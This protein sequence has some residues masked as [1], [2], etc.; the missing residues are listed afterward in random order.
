MQLRKPT[1]HKKNSNLADVN[2][3][4]FFQCILVAL[5]LLATPLMASPASN[6]V[7]EI[8]LEIEE[9]CID[10]AL[11]EE[12]A[13][14][15][16]ERIECWTPSAIDSILTYNGLKQEGIE[17]CGLKRTSEGLQSISCDELQSSNANASTCQ[18]VVTIVDTVTT[19]DLSIG[20]TCSYVDTGLIQQIQN[21]IKDGGP[22][23]LN[24]KSDALNLNSLTVCGVVIPTRLI[25]EYLDRISPCIAESDERSEL[26]YVKIEDPEVC[27]FQVPLNAL[28]QLVADQNP[29]KDIAQDSEAQSVQLVQDPT[30]CGVTIP[31]EAVVDYINRN[32]PCKD[33]EIPQ[34]NF[35]ILLEDPEACGHTIPYQELRDKIL[36]TNPCKDELDSSTDAMEVFDPMG[37]ED[38]EVCQQTIPLGMVSRELKEQYDW[39]DDSSR[40]IW[41]AT[42][43][44]V[45]CD[46]PTVEAPET[47]K[48][49]ESICGLPAPGPLAQEIIAYARNCVDPNNEL[50]THS[51]QPP[52]DSGLFEKEYCDKIWN[53]AT[54]PLYAA[55]GIQDED[56]DGV[57]TIKLCEQDVTVRPGE[58]KPVQRGDPEPFIVLGD[59][60]DD[61]TTNPAPALDIKRQVDP[62]C[63]GHYVLGATVVY[64]GQTITRPVAGNLPC[65]LPYT[66]PEYLAK[67]TQGPDKDR[68]KIPGFVTLHYAKLTVYED[69]T[70]GEEQTRTIEYQ[71]DFDDEDPIVHPRQVWYEVDRNLNKIGDE[72][73]RFWE[74]VVGRALD[75]SQDFDNDGLD[76]VNEFQWDLVPICVENQYENCQD[77]EKDRYSGYGGD[78]WMDG[79]EVF[80]FNDP[81]NDIVGD[82]GIGA[83]RDPDAQND[84]DEDGLP[85][86]GDVDADNDGLLDGDEY[87]SYGL[88]PEF[89]D[90]DCDID[91]VECSAAWDSI[92]RFDARTGNPG[93]GDGINDGEEVYRW[94]ETSGANWN[95]DSD[96][97]GIKNILDPDSDNDELLDGQEFA[98]NGQVL[99]HVEDTDGDGLLDGQEIQWNVDSDGDGLLNAADWD[100]DN[101]G[102]S[103]SWEVHYGFD[104]TNPADANEDPDA[105]LL[106]NLQEFLYNAIENGTPQY[107]GGTDPLDPDTDD[108]ELLDGEEVLYAGTS[109]FYWDTDF[110]TLPDAWEFTYRHAKLNPLVA[111]GGKDADGDSYDYAWCKNIGGAYSNYREYRWQIPA[112]WDSRP[113]SEGGNGV[114]WHGTNPIELDTDGDGAPDGYEIC[115][116]LNPLA[117]DFI[118]GDDPD[119][120]GLDN[121]I[122]VTI[123]TSIQLVDS[124]NDGLCDGG[125]TPNC[126]PYP[127]EYHGWTTTIQGN[128]R[129]VQSNPTDADSDDDFLTDLQEFLLGTLPEDEDTDNDSVIDG[130]E[131]DDRNA[132][133][134]E[135]NTDPFSPDTDDDGLSDHAERVLG[136]DPT[137]QDSDDDGI[138]DGAEVST[139]GT[140]PTNHDTDYDY[141]PDPLELGL[142]TLDGTIPWNLSP[143]VADSDGDGLLDGEEV[144]FYDLDP[145]NSDSDCDLTVDGHDVDP[146][147]SNLGPGQTLTS[148]QRE[149]CGIYAAPESALVPERETLT[150][151]MIDEEGYITVLSRAP[152]SENEVTIFEVG[153]RFEAKIRTEEGEVHDSVFMRVEVPEMEDPLVSSTDPKDY[154]THS[155][156]F[157]LPVGIVHAYSVLA[158]LTMMDDNLNSEV[159]HGTPHTIDVHEFDYTS[160]EEDPGT[161]GWD[162]S[163]HGWE[164]WAHGQA[165]TD[166]QEVATLPEPEPQS[167]S[168]SS[169]DA[170]I[171][172]NEFTGPAAESL[173]SKT[174]VITFDRKEAPDLIGKLLDDGLAITRTGESTVGMAYQ[175][176]I[177]TDATTL[178]SDDLAV[179]FN[180]GFWDDFSA[181]AMKIVDM[182]QAG[183]EALGN[184]VLDVASS[185][186][187]AVSAGLHKAKTVSIGFYQ[188]MTNPETPG[189]FAAKFGLDLIGIGDII[190][191]T[192]GIQEGDWV[193]IG[194]ASA[195]LALSVV[196]LASGGT[197][198]GADI[199][200]T[201]SKNA[202][203]AAKFIDKAV[204]AKPLLEEG[205]KF[206]AKKGDEVLS[207]LHHGATDDILNHNKLIRHSND[208]Q[209]DGKAL[210]ILGDVESIDVT[211]ARNLMESKALMRFVDQQSQ[212]RNADEI[213]DGLKQFGA[214]SIFGAGARSASACVDRVELAN[215]ARKFDR[216]MP[217][218]EQLELVDAIEDI[219]GSGIDGVDALINS[220]KG[221]NAAQGKGHAYTALKVREKLH[222]NPELEKRYSLSNGR[223]MRV[224]AEYVGDN[225]KVVLAEYKNYAKPLG[226]RKAIVQQLENYCEINES[227]FLGNAVIH[228]TIKN[229]IKSTLLDKIAKMNAEI[230]GCN[231]VV[232]S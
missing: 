225:G 209:D 23:E 137:W 84:F 38:V 223:N 115:V 232:K 7:P 185:V 46:E 152:P 32:N 196:S 18:S 83:V 22:C 148:E 92:N 132:V 210:M 100:S 58:S 51:E 221:M 72:Y 199:A 206:M 217:E 229:G 143:I 63:G 160:T 179:Q 91:A 113:I 126:A 159:Y 215:M 44:R 68:D 59:P 181:G 43:D 136:S 111:D 30:I 6:S 105:D 202:Y 2:A 8:P 93:T 149:R 230:P 213:K 104:P 165:G 85:D 200:L 224:D 201:G 155:V 88:F 174:F 40:K 56:G 118:A 175:Y 190:D 154:W 144:F 163:D 161:N 79:P 26:D 135:W 108:D 214:C 119:G 129:H 21:I 69:G 170:S 106:T 228:F 37:M 95:S 14:Q 97:D 81:A 102:I 35:V 207:G 147:L 77:F 78:N 171:G 162:P 169:P 114:W 227:N 55:C 13:K 204:D 212:F 107:W 156:R 189:E 31:V 231:I 186:D 195:G 89:A 194:F 57:H 75:W 168:R 62:S 90:S 180:V 65:P 130:D 76:N 117:E 131:D 142:D 122:E 203:R 109:P 24:P 47:R 219:A 61:D 66:S 133:I 157:P 116:N 17:V 49:D 187:N 120:D 5:I 211:A 150:A 123:G 182:A 222:L 134:E 103:D 124:D 110:D 12:T 36:D 52:Q 98:T 166:P 178:L 145:L 71:V 216:W 15:T 191:L 172:G 138:P 128:Q 87:N 218:S 226:A 19:F 64:A 1:A 112:G 197:L 99:P 146:Y 205:G 151:I 139:Y 167:Q 60:D 101:D 11:R 53:G 67:I 220:I 42:W 184:G 9:S 121:S 96:R 158:T 4:R 177:Y 176:A 153:L 164:N 188:D 70:T 41:K 34:T 33:E 74:E 39:F 82:A 140:S 94:G 16:T 127:G 54:L 20:R 183:A 25:R 125:E 198:A 141:I 73:E 28:L 10:F 173:A 80:Y 48:L 50:L 208:F 192:V 3:S 86:L 27:G 45:P 29:C 193:L